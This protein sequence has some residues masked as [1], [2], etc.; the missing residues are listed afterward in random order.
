MREQFRTHR[1]MSLFLI[2]LSALVV[3]V[4]FDLLSHVAYAFERGERE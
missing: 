3:T 1:V 4:H 2:A